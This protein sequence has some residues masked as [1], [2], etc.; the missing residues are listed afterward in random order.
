[1]ARESLVVL[2]APA[3][4]HAWTH[5]WLPLLKPVAALPGEQVCVRENILYLG[6]RDYGPVYTSADGKTLPR[7]TGCIEIQADE[8]FLASPVRGSM[9]SRYFGPMK[10]GTIRAQAVPVWTWGN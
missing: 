9:D 7:L 1:M 10:V 2:S 5:W 4:V 8:V 6:G 3:S